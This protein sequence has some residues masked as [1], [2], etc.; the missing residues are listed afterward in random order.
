MKRK[1]IA[2]AVFLIAATLYVL[3][4]HKNKTLKYI[5]ENVDAV[6]LIDMKNLKRQYISSFAAHPSLWFREKNKK[7]KTNFIQESGVKIPDFFQIFHVKNTHFLQWYCVLELTDKQ[8]FLAYLKQQK[9]VKKQENTFQKD[10]VFLKIDG[11]KCI[12][13][14]SELAFQSISQSI[15]SGKNVFNADSFIDNSLGSISFI[16]EK[17]IR[18]FSIDLNSD[19]IEIKNTQKAENFSSIISNLQQKQSFLNAEL[20]A[21]N[22]KNFTAF[23]NGNI[24]DSSQITHFNTTAELEQVNDTIITYSY[25]DNFNEIEKKTF[26][27]ITQPNYVIALQSKNAEKTWQYFQNKKWI[28]AQNQ[29]TAIP[30]QPNVIVKNKTGLEIKS[31]RKPIQLSPKLNENYIFVRNNPRLLSSFKTLTA[32]EKRIISSI[33]YIFYGNKGE[34]Y[35]V[36]LKGK[37]EE[38]PLILRW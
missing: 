20:D 11:E 15:S 22:I 2:L 35:Y 21:K 3:L 30:F 28:N 38:L 27:T 18:S 1:I 7:G 33:D 29:F 24:A 9:F 19:E 16:S 4:Y 32:T 17:R 25:D 36:T 8:K 6:V 23:F 26:Q 14:T 12:V 34:D 31:T 5:P 13:G 37:K 10:Q